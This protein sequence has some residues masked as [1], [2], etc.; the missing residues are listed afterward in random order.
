MAFKSI[1]NH[2]PFILPALLLGLFLLVRTILLVR[3]GKPRTV[4]T[5]LGRPLQNILILSF[6]TALVLIP[7]FES[8]FTVYE[9]AVSTRYY[10]QVLQTT[11]LTIAA[12]K[13]A[14]VEYWLDYATLLA[15]LRYQSINPWDHDADMSIVHPDFAPATPQPWPIASRPPSATDSAANISPKLQFL[16][17]HLQQHNLHP[18]YDPTR[19]LLQTRLAPSAPPH[20]DIWLWQASSSPVDSTL[21]LWTADHTVHYNPRRWDE[22]MPL[23]NV[24]GWIGIQGGVSVPSDKHGI[25]SKEFSVYGG[26]YLIS[27]VFRGDCF[28][29]FFNFRWMY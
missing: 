4:I 8:Y 21:Y 9:C 6:L 11:R 24:S 25:S 29:N 17:D 3:P 5:R 23:G 26:S 20:V 22:V 27:S 15:A 16:L 2:N 10:D 1:Q 13:E 14:G 12:L 18:T 7:V 19:H 28:H